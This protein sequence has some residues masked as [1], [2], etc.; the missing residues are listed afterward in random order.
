MIKDTEYRSLCDLLEE[1]RKK[2]N[3]YNFM[4]LNTH[5]LF[6]SGK[7]SRYA[8]VRASLHAAVEHG[9]SLERTQKQLQNLV[10]TVES[11]EGV[12]ISKILQ[13]RGVLNRELEEWL[14][15]PVEPLR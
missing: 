11:R 3:A 1:F 4:C 15:N 10:N 2:S 5:L 9:R 6:E 7:L 14:E 12:P 13:D 8:Y